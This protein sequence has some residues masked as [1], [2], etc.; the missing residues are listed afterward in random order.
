MLS[1]YFPV[2]VESRRSFEKEQRELNA[3]GNHW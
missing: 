1:V 3:V 2:L